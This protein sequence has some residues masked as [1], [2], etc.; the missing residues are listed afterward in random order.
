VAVLALDQR[1][2]AD[3]EV[4]AALALARLRNFSLGNAHAETP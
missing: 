3:R 2:C 4:R 1:W